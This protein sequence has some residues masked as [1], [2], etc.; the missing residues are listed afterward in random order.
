M[1]KLSKLPES[2]RCSPPLQSPV[3][4][5]EQCLDQP[6][7]N[8]IGNKIY[9]IHRKCQKQSKIRTGKLFALHTMKSQPRTLDYR[10]HPYISILKFTFQTLKMGD[11]VI[12]FT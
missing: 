8:N 9:N 10:L 4:L 3:D 2:L 5:C 12:C 11:F 1:Y 6:P 7:N